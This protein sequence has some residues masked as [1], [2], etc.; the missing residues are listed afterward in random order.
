MANGGLAVDGATLNAANLV[1]TANGVQVSLGDSGVVVG[2]NTIEV[3]QPVAGQAATSIALNGHSVQISARSSGNQIIV[4]KEALPA[5]TWRAR[6]D[7]DLVRVLGNGQ[8][9][10]LPTTLPYVPLS[11]PSDSSITSPPK[12]GLVA[13]GR[14]LTS[15]GHGKTAVE[16]TILSKA[17]QSLTL[18][19]GTIASLENGALFIGTQTMAIPTAAQAISYQSNGL[20]VDG[21]TFITVGSAGI[22][23]DGTT[24][25]T[26]GQSMT[27]SDVTV[28]SLEGGA[29]VV[30]SQTLPIPRP[31]QATGFCTKQAVTAEAIRTLANGKVLYNEV[32]LSRD[33]PAVTLS[34]GQ[35]ITLEASSIVADASTIG[36]S[37]SASADA[38]AASE[39]ESAHAETTAAGEGSHT[40]TAIKKSAAMRYTLQSD[41]AC[42]ALVLIAATI[43]FVG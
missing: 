34:D 41:L 15:S 37:M 30:G 1:T 23:M 2:G 29:L 22:A 25:S 3:P 7:N 31:A 36:G 18:K 5:G 17:G 27:L 16:G 24:L 9:S 42:K 26:S 10:V 20:V 28:V 40:P 38:G 35:V 43:L 19:D 11:G 39:M 13:S 4:D 14:T 33:V 12:L 21:Q 8:I 6:I 32:T